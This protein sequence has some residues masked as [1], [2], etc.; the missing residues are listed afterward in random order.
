MDYPILLLDEPTSALDAANR[1]VVSQLIEEAK[2]KGRALVGIF[3]DNEV[4]DRL[5]NR[6]LTFGGEDGAT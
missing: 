2:A 1:E 3:H 4:R 5:C 6:V